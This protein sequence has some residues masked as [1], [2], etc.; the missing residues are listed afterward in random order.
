[1]G[2]LHV[3]IIMDGNGR[4][5]RSR[6]HARFFGHV[7]GV[8]RVQE[9][10]QEAG[11]L[12]LSALTLYAF[13]TE[14][15]KR[16]E[17][18]RE[19]LWRLLRRFLKV[20]TPALLR[21]NVQFR[22]IG[23]RSRLSPAVLSAIRETECALEKCTGLQLTIAVS[24]GARDEI[25]RA[26]RA[27]ARECFEGSMKPEQMT[28]DLFS[29]FLDTAPL[30]S[31]ADVDLVLRTSGEQRL[32]NFLL[33]QAAYAEL[34]FVNKPWPEFTAGDLRRA[35]QQFSSRKRRFGGVE[36]ARPSETPQESRT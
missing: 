18:E 26:A 2:P 12:G 34:T 1:M 21:S 14:N 23:D 32:S 7:R 29:Q 4:W 17:A 10:V 33:W 8:R 31:L 11:N 28:E 30:G 6:G 24:Y 3:A 27:F 15:W 9:V 36:G 5:A 19:V 35:V 16:P 25:I 22:V 20:E 13:S